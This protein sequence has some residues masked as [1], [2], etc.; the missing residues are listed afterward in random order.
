MRTDQH[1][2]LH[3]APARRTRAQAFTALDRSRAVDDPALAQAFA[4]YDELVGAIESEYAGESRGIRRHA[5][6]EARKLVAAH[7][8]MGQPDIS[9]TDPGELDAV[10]RR[11]GA[12]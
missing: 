7:L 2:F 12:H 3:H 5:L 1:V 10:L 11:N 9:D 6:R 4:L 8:K